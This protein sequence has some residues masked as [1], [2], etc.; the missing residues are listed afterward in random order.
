MTLRSTR[1]NADRS[2]VLVIAV[3]T[4]VLY[5]FGLLACVLYTTRMSTTGSGP[6]AGKVT[7]LHVKYRIV[8]AIEEMFRRRICGSPEKDRAVAILKR[9]LDGADDSLRG[10]IQT[11]LKTIESCA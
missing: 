10:A 1:S 9:F 2:D 11:A 6:V 7:R 3:V 4:L 8:L 5:L